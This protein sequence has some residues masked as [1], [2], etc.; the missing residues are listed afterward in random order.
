M[1]MPKDI[2][3]RADILRDRMTQYFEEERKKK[4]IKAFNLEVSISKKSEELGVV[5][6]VDDIMEYIRLIN[7]I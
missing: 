3:E 4:K 7:T 1:G 2:K 6:L 5:D